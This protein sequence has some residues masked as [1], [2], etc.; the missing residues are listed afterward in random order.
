MPDSRFPE[1]AMYFSTRDMARLGLLMLRGCKWREAQ[2][3]PRAWCQR[4]TTLV[5]PQ[6]DIHPTQLG[7]GAWADRWGYGLLWWVWDAPEPAGVVSGPYSGAYT[8]MGAYGQYV[9]VLP[10]LDLVALRESIAGNDVPTNDETCL[11]VP[12]DVAGVGAEPIHRHPQRVAV[13]AGAPG[14]VGA[15]QAGRVMLALQRSALG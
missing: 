3:V 12:A 9:T 4:I 7:S 10:T 15:V 13:V 5:T 8:A 11:L 14:D 1:Y 6:R 2:L